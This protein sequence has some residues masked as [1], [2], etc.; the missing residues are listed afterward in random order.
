MKHIAVLIFL[1]FSVCSLNA[2]KKNAPVERPKLVVGLV[3]DQMR[4]DF[5][6]RYQEHYGSEGFNRL[7]RDGHS[8]ENMMINYLPS[9]TGPG[10]ACIYTGSVPAI[11][12][13][14]G[15]DWLDRITGNQV[16]CTEDVSVLA[17]GGTQ[18]AGKMSPKNLLA[19]TITDE[20]RLAT[21]FASRTVAVSV[22][23][24]GAI[25]PGGHTANAAYW[26]DDSNGVFMSSTFY[27]K[28]LPAWVQQFNAGQP[29][30][31]Y[32]S[33]DWNTLYPVE[34]YTSSTADTNQYEGKFTGE[35]HSGFPHK[36][37]QFRLA[38]IRKTPYGNS[39]VLDFARAA[40][41]QEQLGKQ[42]QTDFLCVSLS[43]TDYVG[44]QFG[45]NS[46]ET[47]DTYLRLDRDLASFLDYLDGAVGAGN[48]TLFLTADHG[49]AHNPQ[50]LKDRKIPAGYFYGNKLATELNTFLR[51]RYGSDRLIREV[52]D[53]H[54]WLNHGLIDSMKLDEAQIRKQLIQTLAYHAEIMYATDMNASFP[55]AMPE[56]LSTMARNGYNSRRSG[57]ILLLLN[58]GWL[59]AYATT[60]TTHGTWNPY[61][62]H[63]PMIWYGWGIKKGRTR[64]E[65]AMTDIAATIA[66]LLH[67][68]MPNG[69]IG[70]CIPEVL[71]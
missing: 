11:H 53:N 67:I 50:F 25:L 37:N 9:F 45:P 51:E 6:Y 57:D 2:Q 28:A 22:K 42:E 71:K 7:L 33:K 49:V 41:E 58:P 35:Q 56:P 38:D 65:T 10:H 30:K 47:E 23:D 68:Q 62:T 16:Y 4:Y 70:H 29:A 40:I 55:G 27:C 31:G 64:R 17:V 61:D 12:G 18:R 69:C 54:I 46:I 59:D 21:N 60:G 36:T 66:T 13:I 39:L 24:R 5:L 52:G 3:I 19:T 1:V 43:S 14:A 63:I 20:L 15:N 26:L 48:Y 44:H 8:C 34:A 32:L